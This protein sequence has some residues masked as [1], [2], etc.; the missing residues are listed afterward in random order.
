MI[1]KKIT[2]KLR[3][4]TT[5]AIV[6]KCRRG[7]YFASETTEVPFLCMIYTLLSTKP[8]LNATNQTTCHVVRIWLMT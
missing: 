1:K 8:P 5:Y 6:Q 3:S 2:Q 7:R 4:L